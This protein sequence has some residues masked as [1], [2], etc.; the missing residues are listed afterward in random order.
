MSYSYIIVLQIQ[1]WKIIVFIVFEA[2]LLSGIV[3]LFI[4]MIQFGYLAKL[5]FST[6]LRSICISLCFVLFCLSVLIGL[7]IK[8]VSMFSA[9]IITTFASMS[10]SL[11]NLFVDFE[12]SAHWYL[13]LSNLTSIFSNVMLN[14]RSSSYIMHCG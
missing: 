5:S 10:K 12:Q 13:S 9:L 6:S 3:L 1:I 11:C 2:L 7:I 8:L 4:C 14:L